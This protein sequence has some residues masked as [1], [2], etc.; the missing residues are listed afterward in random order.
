MTCDAEQIFI[1]HGGQHALSIALGMIAKPG[2]TVLTETFTYSGMLALSVQNAYRLQG[3]ATDGEG[4]VPESLDLAFTE[5]GAR[6]VYCM[7]TLQ[8]PTGTVMSPNTAAGH[9]RD[10]AQARR[11]SGRR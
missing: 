10:R 7:P 9:R 6:V 5:T 11:L 8:T 4:L 3:V 1:T 2:D